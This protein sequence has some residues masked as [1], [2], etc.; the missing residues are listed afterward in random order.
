MT[1]IK[2][3]PDVIKICKQLKEQVSCDF[4]GLAIQNKVGPDVRWHYAVGNLNDKYKRITV[5]FGKGI[6]GKIISSGT[7]MM[8]TNFPHHVTGKVTDYPIAL[9]EKLNTCYAV[10]LFFNHV[11]KGVLLVGNREYRSFNDSERERVLE[12]AQVLEEILKDYLDFK[13]G[14]L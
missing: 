3:L 13:S 2:E 10:P 6:A 8:H 12:E 14:G 9:A 11:P 5:R 1:E 4:V 7:P